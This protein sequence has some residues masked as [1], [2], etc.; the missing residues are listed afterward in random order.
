MA[1]IHPQSSPDIRFTGLSAYDEKA[2]RAALESFL[3]RHALDRWG[4]NLHLS[5][6]GCQTWRL[7]VSVVA[8]PE[9]EYSVRSTHVVIDRTVDLGDVVDSCLEAHFNA[10]MNRQAILRSSVARKAATSQ[11]SLRSRAAKAV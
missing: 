2:S 3:E 9:F 8:P 4:L 1:T 7:D 6:A 10:C 5:H 11:S